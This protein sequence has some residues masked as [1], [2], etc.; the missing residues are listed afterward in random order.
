MCNCSNHTPFVADPHY[1]RSSVA[2]AGV[3]ASPSYFEPLATESFVPALTHSQVSYT[4]SA[5]GQSWYVE[6]APEEEASALF[7]M[8]VQGPSYHPLAEEVR[9]AKEFLSVVAHGGFEAKACSYA[10]CP[11]LRLKG[12]ALCHLH[13]SVV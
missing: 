9:A 5:C 12:R 8:K 2:L 4:C 11:N 7:A 13:L 1:W 10:Q 6:C 3:S